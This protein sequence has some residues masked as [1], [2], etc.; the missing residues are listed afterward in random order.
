MKTF[1]SFLTLFLALIL[2][3]GVLP[4]GAITVSASISAKSGDCTLTLNGTV[5]TVS[6][7]GATE[8]FY[9]LSYYNPEMMIVTEIIIKEGVTRIGSSLFD[10]CSLLESITIP[11]SIESIGSNAFYGCV[12]LKNVYIK[13]IAKWCCIQFDSVYAN[14]LSYADN[15][16]LNSEL[17]TGI[18][19]P[20]GVDKIGDYAFWGYNLTSITIPES[21]KTIGTLAFYKNKITN[22]TIPNGVSSIERSAFADCELLTSVYFSPS[23][24]SIGNNAFSDSENIQYVYI[25]DIKK[26]CGVEFENMYANPVYYAK[27]IYSNNE[28]LTNIRITKDIK[29]IKEH[30]FVNCRSIKNVFI[31]NEAVP[32]V[33]SNAF[34]GCS[35]IANLCFEGN[36]E[37]WNVNKTT[38]EINISR[39]YNLQNAAFYYDCI[40]EPG[41][42]KSVEIYELPNKLQF[43]EN[44]EKLICDGG[45]LKVNFE[46]GAT[47]CHNFSSSNVEGF[48][49]TILGKQTLTVK[50][51]DFYVEYEIEI[52]PKPLTFI[53]VSHLPIKTNY[54]IGEPL[55]LA[56]SKIVV[57]YAEGN[58][59]FF[60][61]TADMVSGFNCNKAGIQI[62]NITYKGYYKTQ[63][64]VT[65]YAKANPDLNGDENVNASDIVI[66]RKEL[67]NNS[68]YNEIYDINGDGTFDIR[69]LINLKKQILS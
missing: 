53:A 68:S 56:G 55:D 63:L 2:I 18:E 40:T 24:T 36:I 57:G 20:Y 64:A 27:K 46:G 22:L 35:N 39:N 59:E 30:A 50:Y 65:V 34:W 14:P 26:W 42:I 7:S 33:E 1:K 54:I 5:L 44:E 32:N 9:S 10:T 41:E 52:I 19:I 15:L 51:L 60:D 3:L 48:D 62:L 43:I 38:W 45:M 11:E 66:L 29:I 23:V 8:D 16:Y 67:L 4:L 13:N 49:N 21:V 31:E 37:E 69:D 61:I 28:L 17:V 25:S 6:G 47:Q 58:Y 12:N